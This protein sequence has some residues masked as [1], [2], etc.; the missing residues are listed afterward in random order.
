MGKQILPDRVILPEL[1]SRTSDD[2]MKILILLLLLVFLVNFFL[3]STVQRRLRRNLS[4]M[5]QCFRVLRLRGN[6]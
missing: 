5:S 6:K 3:N 1:S 4:K 2:T